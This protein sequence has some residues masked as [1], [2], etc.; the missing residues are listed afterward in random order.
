[1]TDHTALEAAIA[2][3]CLI[4]GDPDEA[5]A[6]LTRIPR[7]KRGEV[8]HALDDLEMMLSRLGRDHG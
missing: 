3:V 5:R 4:Q 1:M 2:L 7:N 6:A 8:K